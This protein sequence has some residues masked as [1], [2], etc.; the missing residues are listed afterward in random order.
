[1]TTVTRHSPME[2]YQCP[3]QE[4]ACMLSNTTC[5]I[6]TAKRLLCDV[7]RAPHVISFTFYYAQNMRKLT[8]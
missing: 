1:M 6:V 8:K 3:T 7:L 5:S 2:I 4:K